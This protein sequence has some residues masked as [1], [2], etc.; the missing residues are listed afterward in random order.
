MAGFP[1]LPQCQQTGLGKECVTIPV[2]FS[3]PDED[4]HGNAVDIGDFQFAYFGNTQ[5]GAVNVNKD[6]Q[7]ADRM[8]NAKELCNLLYRPNFGKR[9]DMF[10]SCSPAIIDIFF[11]NDK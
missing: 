7:V 5:T 3:L 9:N 10:K 8:D 2:A 4:T 11:Q 6:S 1:I